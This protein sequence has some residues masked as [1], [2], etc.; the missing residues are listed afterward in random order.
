VLQNHHSPNAAFHPRPRCITLIILVRL[1]WLKLTAY[2]LLEIA[3]FIRIVSLSS[4]VCPL[5]A[6]I[7]R[8]Q[9]E[10]LS[11]YDVERMRFNAVRM[12]GAENKQMRA[13]ALIAAQNAAGSESTVRIRR[14]S[15]SCSASV[16]LGKAG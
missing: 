7:E 12:L 14:L 9:R 16:D 13:L 10:W 5:A 8:L 6:E 1:L 15:S 2:K 11:L 3:E 4:G